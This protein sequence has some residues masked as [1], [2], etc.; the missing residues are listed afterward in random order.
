MDNYIIQQIKEENFA[1]CVDMINKSFLE[2]AKQQAENFDKEK[3]HTVINASWLEIESKL[4]KF[5]YGIWVFDELCGYL[6]FARLGKS[7]YE[8][9]KLTMLHEERKMGYAKVLVDFAV[10]MVKCIGGTSVRINILDKNTVLKKWYINYGFK[11]YSTSRGIATL[12][13]DLK[14]PTI[15]VEQK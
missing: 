4:N 6:Q 15:F 3:E 7:T 11:E 1:D 12:E 2:S 10:D 13:L 14:V 9:E 5:M 8:I